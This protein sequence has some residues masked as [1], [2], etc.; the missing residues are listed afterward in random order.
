MKFHRLIINGEPVQAAA[1]IDV[2]SP[3]T[4]GWT[5][6]EAR[7]YA[8]H[9]GSAMFTPA[10]VKKMRRLMAGHHLPKRLRD[11]GGQD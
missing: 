8:R 11:A 5:E 4:V 6:A 7:E 10:G 3:F 1:V 2:V 9:S